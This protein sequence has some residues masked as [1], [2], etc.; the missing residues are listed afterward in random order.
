MRRLGF[1]PAAGFDVLGLGVAWDRAD[2][3]VD[4]LVGVCATLPAVDALAPLFPQCGLILG[5]T[6]FLGLLDFCIRQERVAHIVFGKDRAWH[7]WIG[8][9][10]SLDQRNLVGRLNV[11]LRPIG[12]FHHGI[13]QLTTKAVEHA[14]IH[15]RMLCAAEEVQVH[16][17]GHNGRHV[18]ICHSR[19]PCFRTIDQALFQTI[20]GFFPCHWNRV[21]VQSSHSDSAQLGARNAVFGAKEVFN[22]CDR[23][24]VFPCQT[25]LDPAQFRVAEE[26][27]QTVAALIR[28]AQQRL[29]FGRVEEVELVRTVT[30]HVRIVQ[31][32]QVWRA[33]GRVLGGRRVDVDDAL[34]AFLNT[35]HLTTNLII[36]NE[37]NANL[38]VCAAFEVTGKFQSAGA[39]D[40]QVACVKAR[41]AELQHELWLFSKALFIRRLG[42]SGEVC[43]AHR[44][45]KSACRQKRRAH[46]VTASHFEQIATGNPVDFVTNSH[47]ILPDAYY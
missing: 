6:H 14:G 29:G 33:T 34:L 38:A 45:T 25:Q 27:L 17:L 47:A 31:Y 24:L 12:R 19:G 39:F 22:R 8:L 32:V 30:E 44:P 13:L 41:S 35:G 10:N 20:K 21:Q 28:L 46:A 37:F 3:V 36:P 11:D 1:P 26:E 42:R 9:T 16:R 23:W 43:Q 7:L 4:F 18:G 2:L 15:C 5:R 40:Q